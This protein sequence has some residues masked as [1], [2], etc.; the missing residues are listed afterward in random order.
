LHV[1]RNKDYSRCKIERDVPL[2]YH[3][4]HGLVFVYIIAV[5][6]QYRVCSIKKAYNVN[7]ELQPFCWHLIS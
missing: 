3:I 1:L 4:P 2:E 7:P 5:V 6:K